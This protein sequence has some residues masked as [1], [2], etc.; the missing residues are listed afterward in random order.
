MSLNRDEHQIQSSRPTAYQTKRTERRRISWLFCSSVTSLTRVTWFAELY[1]ENY[2]VTSL[3]KLTDLQ[4][5]LQNLRVEFEAAEGNKP[6]FTNSKFRRL[7]SAVKKGNY[8]SLLYF[9]N[10]F[11]FRLEKDYKVCVEPCGV[12]VFEVIKLNIYS[13]SFFFHS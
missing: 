4:L 6:K 13:S 2:G 12:I 3:C 5:W 11:Y 8:Y 1:P 10:R 7:G 9:S